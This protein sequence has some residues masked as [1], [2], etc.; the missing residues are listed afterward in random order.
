MLIQFNLN[1]PDEA[2]VPLNI[3]NRASTKIGKK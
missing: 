3:R 2:V 1:T